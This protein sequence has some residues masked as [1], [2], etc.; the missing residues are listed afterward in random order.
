MT[1][2]KAVGRLGAVLAVLVA[3]GSWACASE[4][5]FVTSW[6]APTAEPLNMRDQPV[7]AVVMIQ[8]TAKRQKAE[9]LLAKEITKH[10]AKGIPM[11][12]LFAGFAASDEPAA[13]AA[14]ER[15]GVKGVVVMRPMGS[16]VKTETHTYTDPMYSGYWGGYYGYG[17]GAPYGGPGYWGA[18]Y[19]WT[20]ANTPHGKDPGT[21]AA[22]AAPYY[23][24]SDTYTT[25]TKVVMVEVL[26]YSLKQNL[27][28]W[29]G[30][31][32]TVDPGDLDD[33]VKKLAAA[34]AKELGAIRLIWS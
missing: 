2:A 12:T 29:V 15:A 24:T 5:T 9:D 7:A 20:P 34:T 19:A 10:G 21:P 11:Y 13:R 27:L 25:K 14:V 1:S 31:S 28:V 4:T 17:W 3:L 18:G 32:E 6:R 16:K 8:D 30:Q 26:V 23:N 33:F 22:Y